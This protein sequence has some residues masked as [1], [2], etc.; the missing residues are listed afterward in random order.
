[1][2]LRRAAIVLSTVVAG[3]GTGTAHAS[4]SGAG[5]GSGVVKAAQLPTA[6]A[7]SASGAVHSVTVT[8]PAATIGGQNVAG[9][10][11]KRYTTGGTAQTVGAGCSG[12]ISGLTCTEAAV[13]SGTW[14]YTVT[15]VQ[16]S[17][18]GTESPQGASVT[19]QSPGLS[20]TSSTTVT[21]L[22]ATLNASLTNLVPG[23]SVTFRL[24]DRSTGTVL[25]STLSPTTVPASGAVT[26]T[27]TLPA[28]VT[29]GSHTV[30][31]I[32]GLAVGQRDRVAELGAAGDA[33]ARVR[34]LDRGSG[35]G[36]VVDRDGVG[37]RGLRAR[38]VGERHGVGLRARVE[39]RLGRQLC[40]A[41]VVGLAADRP[42]ARAQ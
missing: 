18:T 32:D 2:K 24:D 34:C 9:Y 25:S 35:G 8:W 41:V 22:P 28:G 27:V 31:A 10:I 4:W 5:S 6:T 15:P 7:P 19:V 12:T 11:V 30:Y 40:A 42:A 39:R 38:A 1:M 13:P 17:W 20:F 33:A 26:A 29:N 23:Q 37:S 36:G 21:S 3:L 16:A 14:R